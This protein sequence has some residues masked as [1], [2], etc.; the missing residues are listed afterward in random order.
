MQ[1]VW[2]HNLIGLEIPQ[3]PKG[4]VNILHTSLTKTDCVGPSIGC[5]IYRMGS[6]GNGVFGRCPKYS[7]G[8]IH[9]G[10]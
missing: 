2:F 9:I 10:H 5:S 7:V 1:C 6:G 8:A 3:M 4:V